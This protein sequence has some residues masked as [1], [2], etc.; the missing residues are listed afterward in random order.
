MSVALQCVSEELIASVRLKFR[1]HVSY[2]S[3]SCTQCVSAR[4][5]S[6]ILVKLEIIRTNLSILEGIAYSNI[7]YCGF[8]IGSTLRFTTYI[9]HALATVITFS[10]K[11]HS[12]TSHHIIFISI[13]SRQC[14]HSGQHSQAPRAADTWNYLAKVWCISLLS[15]E[16]QARRVRKLQYLWFHILN[17]PLAKVN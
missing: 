15:H 9:V 14:F 12:H 2:C 10:K 8:P 17:L 13:R 6:L 1:T 16:A 5:S 3:R 4:E 7:S 11:F